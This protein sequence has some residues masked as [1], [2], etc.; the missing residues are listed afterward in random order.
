MTQVNNKASSGMLVPAKWMPDLE[1]PHWKQ[2]YNTKVW[3]SN[4]TAVYSPFV[5]EGGRHIHGAN[6]A[7][8]LW[9]PTTTPGRTLVDY[10]TDVAGIDLT[11]PAYL[12]AGT[13][14]TDATGDAEVGLD[15]FNPPLQMAKDV[16]ALA[17]QQSTG[18]AT[19]RRTTWGRVVAINH[20]FTIVNYSRFPLE[21]FYAVLPIGAQF[22][23]LEATTVPHADLVGTQYRKFVVGGVRDAGDRGSRRS[24]PVAANLKSIFPFQYESGPGIHSGTGNEGESA[25][26]GLNNATTS[27]IITTMPPGQST[28][29]TQFDESAGTVR[30]LPALVCR[31]YGKLQT[32]INVGTTIVG[33]GT[34]GDTDTNS[35]TIHADMSWLVEMINVS[36]LSIAHPG[37]EAYPDQT[38]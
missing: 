30:Q 4:A 9:H 23:H 6:P 37:E 25:W 26:F 31:I 20:T 8:R 16:F 7:Q 18:E 33:T 1:Y 36:R 13:T 14:T 10:T 21:I 32:P 17:Q 22:E 27:S 12:L 29:T 19:T 38:A 5:V 35:Y 15:Y 11:T 24:F 28:S 34:L 3:M 2:W